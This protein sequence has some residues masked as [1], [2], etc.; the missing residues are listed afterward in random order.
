MNARPMLA[1]VNAFTKLLKFR[2]LSGSCITEVALYSSVVL[3]AV[4]IHD[5]RGTTAHSE[6]NM[7]TK[8]LRK[9]LT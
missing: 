6:K 8:Y 7:S 3:K 4:V 5:I 2:K 1:V 9:P